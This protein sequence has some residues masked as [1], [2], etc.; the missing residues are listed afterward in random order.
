LAAVEVETLRDEFLATAIA[1]GERLCDQARW[2]GDAC[3]WLGL[4]PVQIAGGY[5][6]DRVPLGPA[7]YAGA[8]GN[9]LFLGYLWRATQVERFRATA[10]GAARAALRDVG[11]VAAPVRV[12]FYAGWT[13]IAYALIEIAALCDQPVLLV[14]G[15]KL[16]RR[17]KSLRADAQPAEVLLGVAGTIGPLLRLDAIELAMQFGEA[18]LASSRVRG[19]VRSWTPYGPMNEY[20]H[21]DLTGLAHGASGI[22]GALLELA[23]AT[24]DERFR[25]AAEQGFAYE[26]T[27]FIAEQG[28]WLDLRYMPGPDGDLNDGKTCQIQWCHGAAGIGLTRL[29]A[30]TLLGDDIYRAEAEIATHTVA[31]DLERYPRNWQPNFSLCHG[32]AG[33]AELLLEAASVLANPRWRAI[34]ERMAWEGIRRFAR[35]ETPWPGAL[36]KDEIPSLITGMAGT[37]LFYLRLYDETLAPSVLWNAGVPP[38]GPAA[39]SPPPP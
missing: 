1:I 39:S 14:H 21:G 13:G 2:D 23:H 24:G 7:I 38:A 17:I 30:F 36:G 11:S 6:H 15:R 27:H 12:S 10:I 22:A 20:H 8:A 25:E 29:R 34:A 19:E 32:V 16:L 28:N 4:S 26:R 31:A 9:A 33:N 5:R 18:L 3:D 37:G 35:T